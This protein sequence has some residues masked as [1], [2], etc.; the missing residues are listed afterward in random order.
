MVLVLLVVV[1]RCGGV[2]GNDGVSGNDGVYWLHVSH[3]VSYNMYFVH[4][5]LKGSAFAFFLC[6]IVGF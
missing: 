5:S 1:V 6:G 4:S 2:G 3:Q